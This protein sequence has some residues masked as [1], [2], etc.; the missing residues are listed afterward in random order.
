M[1]IPASGSLSFSQLQTEWGGSNPISL[2]EYYSGSL[3]G[4]TNDLSDSATP[5]VGTHSNSIYTPA[6]KVVGA[7]TTYYYNNG[8][9]NS[10][11][12]T[13]GSTVAPALG[14]S[15]ASVTEI[16]GAD[17]T[18]NSGAIPASGAI[19]MNKFRG[20]AKATTTNF[21]CY[22]WYAQ[23]NSGGLYNAGVYGTLYL[24]IGGHYGAASETAGNWTGV[25][26]RY[27]TTTAE[28]SSAQM[29]ATTWYG[30]DTNVVNGANGAQNNKIHRT[31]PNIGNV[32][33]FQWTLPSTSAY[34]SFSGTVT[35]SFQF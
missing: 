28:G 11:I 20:T 24:W 22:G 9:A 26:F 34:A 15:S 3:S 32:T 25:P 31:Y 30:S 16:S 21:T 4:T 17:T 7:Y 1:A 35:M 5:T 10:N 12:R 14:S 8:W 29:P 2:N 23:Q 18:G 19:D 6:T 33:E 13:S 27:I